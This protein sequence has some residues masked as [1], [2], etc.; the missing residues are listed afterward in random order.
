MRPCQALDE[1]LTDK[2]E[3]GEEHNDMEEVEKEIELVE[4]D[5]EIIACCK[6][7]LSHTPTKVRV[8]DQRDRRPVLSKWM[9]REVK[10]TVAL[11]DK[12]VK[13]R[14]FACLGLKS[15]WLILG[16]LVCETSN[17]LQQALLSFRT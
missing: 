9:K 11:F 14:N 12:N 15:L 8:L 10:E 2:E 13:P 5:V 6:I 16:N 17:G 7:D 1:A 3:E 4:E